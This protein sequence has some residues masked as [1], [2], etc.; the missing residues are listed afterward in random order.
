MRDDYLFT[1]EMKPYSVATLHSLTKDKRGKY[2]MEDIRLLQ[3]II[4]G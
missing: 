3:N 4:T 1:D 2:T